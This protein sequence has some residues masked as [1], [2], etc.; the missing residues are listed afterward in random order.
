MHLARSIAE[1]G[2]LLLVPRKLSVKLLDFDLYGSDA[3]VGL[4]NR[5]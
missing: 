2:Q 4:G 3:C 1:L 5:A